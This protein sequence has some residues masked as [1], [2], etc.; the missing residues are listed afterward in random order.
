MPQPITRE[1]ALNSASGNR[2]QLLSI[3]TP[4]VER[5]VAPNGVQTITITARTIEIVQPEQP[6]YLAGGTLD[7]TR[8]AI[9]ELVNNLTSRLG[10]DRVTA[11]TCHNSHVPERSFSLRE[12]PPNYA[13]AVKTENVKTETP[14]VGTTRRETTKGANRKITT[15]AP[16]DETLSIEN[17]LID[18]PFSLLD[19]PRPIRVIA[20][21]PDRP[22]SWIDWGT[23]K[24]VVLAAS[25]PERIAEEWWHAALPADASRDYFRV[26][27]IGGRWLWIF[28][29]NRNEKWFLHGL[30][31]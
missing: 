6:D 2:L 27:D 4:L 26:Q 1:M 17:A 20:L 8:S 29:D 11:L 7:T 10:A 3:L 28:R 5:I 14:K 15:A 16:L 31:N 23:A 24:G 18:R 13:P 21:L 19:T 12:L 22:P 9:R 25:G 30:W